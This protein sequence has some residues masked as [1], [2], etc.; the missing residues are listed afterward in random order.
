MTIGMMLRAGMFGVACMFA[1][2]PAAAEEKQDTNATSTA[3]A[4]K[5]KAKHS[6]HK[7][8]E[9]TSESKPKRG[10]FNSEA[11]AKAHCKGDVVWIDRDHFNHYAG[12]REYGKQPGVFAC[13]NG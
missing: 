1:V 11:E 5:A 8:S 7:S 10:E 2:L 13:D 12:S 3:P 4:P 6:E 9:S